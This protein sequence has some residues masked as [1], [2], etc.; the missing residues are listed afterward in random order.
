M[1]ESLDS[2]AMRHCRCPISRSHDLASPLAVHILWNRG[3]GPALHLR[4]HQLPLDLSDQ[5]SPCVYVV[6]SENQ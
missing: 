6:S 5:L 3:S 4:A 1:V 2:A